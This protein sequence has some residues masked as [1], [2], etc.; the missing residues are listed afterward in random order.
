[1]LKCKKGVMLQGVKSELLVAI[2]FAER[3]WEEHGSQLTIT[4]I[5]DGQ[6]SQNSLHYKGLAFDARTKDIGEAAT[7]EAIFADLKVILTPL[8]YDVVFEGEGEANEHIHIEFD[9]K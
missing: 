8:G 6:H 7:K 2:Y 3:V 5:T 4:S 9:P 1:M